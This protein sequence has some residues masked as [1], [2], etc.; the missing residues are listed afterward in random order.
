MVLGV[1]DT[2]KNSFSLNFFKEQPSEGIN[3]VG[4][5]NQRALILPSYAP[6]TILL[7]SNLMHRTSSSWPSRTRRQAPHSM[8]HSCDRT[9]FIDIFCRIWQRKYRVT[10]L[11]WNKL[12]LTSNYVLCGASGRGKVLVECFLVRSPSSLGSIAAAVLA[13]RP[14]EHLWTLN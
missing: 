4:C 14:V 7:E 1:E 11:A 6:E 2:K 13:K 10:I 3:S 5:S 8:S 9:D 12:L